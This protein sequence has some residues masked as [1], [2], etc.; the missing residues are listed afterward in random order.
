MRYPS[1]HGLPLTAKGED[2]R[3]LMSGPVRGA[4]SALENAHMAMLS[5]SLILA[6]WSARSVETAGPVASWKDEI[7]GLE[8][9]QA[10]AGAQPVKQAAAL[11]DAYDAIV[12]DGVNDYLRLAAVT[13][14][15][16][17]ATPG[18]MFMVAAK[19]ALDDPSVSVTS[20]VAYGGTG[21]GTYR[22]IGKLGD[23]PRIGDGTTWAHLNTKAW[24]EPAVL[25]AIFAAT[26]YT[27]RFNGEE[28]EVATGA[29]LNTGTTSVTVGASNA[30]TAADFFV[31]PISQLI[32]TPTLTTA[33]IQQMEG[34][35]AY[36]Y[37]LMSK[38]V[39][40]HPFALPL[41]T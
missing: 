28:I 13:G 4:I 3:G 11:N 18:C 36:E 20:A 29:T 5:S 33:Q 10:T 19:T 17:G 2:V 7:A 12:F 34:W 39:S 14:L 25:A 30:V 27:L 37:G 40:G 1:R 9:V 24:T 26:E 35:L 16:T 32:I 15:P 31:G 22:S 6:Q 41:L 21:D 23:S 38:L 8:L